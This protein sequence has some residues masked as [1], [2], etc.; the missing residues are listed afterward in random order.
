MIKVGLTGGIGT[1]K[2]TVARIFSELGVPIYNADFQA[3]K[4][5]Q[6]TEI[7]EKVAK[8][9]QLTLDK[10]NQFDLKELA[11]VAF[12]NAA[13]IQWLNELIHPLVS[14]DFQ[15]WC[16]KSDYSYVIMESAIIYEAFLEDLFDRVIVVAATEE[17]TIQRLIERDKTN[18]Y[19]INKRK[20][21]QWK[22]MDKI[23]KA[24]YV[25]ENNDKKALIPKVLE[26]HNE[27]IK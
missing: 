10:E 11:K 14:K 23:K 22:Q 15:Q 27:L 1:G 3:K 18:H 25:I 20:S 26:I 6:R 4:I 19:E 17:L 12:E 9:F 24:D 13:N 21:L 5:Y 16:E 8:K 7:A 2:S